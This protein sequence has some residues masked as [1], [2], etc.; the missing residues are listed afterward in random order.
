MIDFKK[1]KA[2]FPIFKHHPDL[3][4]LDNASTTQKPKVVIEGIINFY[5]KGNA[6][7][8]RG[9]YKIAAETSANYDSVR[10][11]VANFI[12]APNSKNIVFTSG[13]TEAINLVTHS[14]LAP[15]LHAG[16]NVIISAMEHHANLIPWQVL[17]KK[18]GAELRIIPMER[19]GK[20]NMTEFKKLLTPKTK[21]VAVVH[22]SNSLGTINPIE[23]I[24][25]SA[26][27]LQ[28]P[29]LIDG[30][31]SVLHYPVN[32]SEMDC[33]FFVFSGHKLFGPTGVGVLYGKEALLESNG[34]F[35]IWR[36][37]DQRSQF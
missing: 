25:D 2:D 5:E 35:Y 26:H 32:V 8:H 19:S 29:V 15:R 36:R 22:V 37:Y 11:K 31:Q 9:L 34:S 12:G 14:F 13:T 6:N 10:S 3:V 17:C 33:D 21:M 4:Y 16:D 28:I 24:I 23:E 30:A 7:I 27:K 20:L 1:V 18:K